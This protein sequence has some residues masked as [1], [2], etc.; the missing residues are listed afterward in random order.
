M[1]LDEL[2]SALQSF[3]GLVRDNY[4]SLSDSVKEQVGKFLSTAAQ[5]ASQLSQEVRAAPIPDSARL[6]WEL[7]G[8]NPEPF[9]KYIQQFPAP[10]LQL[11]ASSPNRILE[12]VEKLQREMPPERLGEADGIPEAWLNSSNVYGYQYDPRTQ[13]LQVRFNNGGIYEYDSIPKEIYDLFNAGAIP[14]RTDGEN[15]YGSWWKGKQPSLGA[16][17]YWL[18]R[19]G[20]FPYKKLN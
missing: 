4:E 2:K 18:I 9:A 6:L 3:V 14:A 11:I 8:R 15:E 1:A 19:E 16:T 5:K 20:G 13:K 17:F 7:A 10:E 12:T